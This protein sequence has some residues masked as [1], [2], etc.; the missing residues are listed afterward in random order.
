MTCY[1]SKKGFTLVELAIVMTII[2]LLIGGILK[3]QELL[4]NARIN[5]FVSQMKAY[6]AAIVTFQDTYGALP[7]D[8]GNPGNLLPNCLSGTCMIGGNG[9]GTFARYGFD[10]VTETCNFFLHMSKAN[11]ISG[12]L[13]GGDTAQCNI[14]QAGENSAPENAL[15]F[16]KFKVFKMSNIDGQTLYG[17]MR[18]SQWIRVDAKLDDND[19][20]HGTVRPE[21]CTIDK[22]N[23]TYEYNIEAENSAYGCAG[24]IGF[25]NLRWSWLN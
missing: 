5:A 24:W 8:I 13:A 25:H 4:E 18:V 15:F 19:P 2:G 17:N 16:P 1:S 23:G 21:E 3:G 12:E 11:L 9:N 6:D 14:A 10:D 20:Q 7:G 22:G